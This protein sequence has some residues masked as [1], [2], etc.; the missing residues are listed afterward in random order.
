MLNIQT[1]SLYFCTDEPGSE[2]HKNDSDEENSD[3]EERQSDLEDDEE[4]DERED[5]SFLEGDENP[6]LDF[7][8]DRDGCLD[9][10]KG[11]E[12]SESIFSSSRRG[13][14]QTRHKKQKL[15]KEGMV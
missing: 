10:E 4:Q 9:T 11:G 6:S 2:P 15:A 1:V 13:S 3:S 12:K 8:E 14:S 5:N 7:V